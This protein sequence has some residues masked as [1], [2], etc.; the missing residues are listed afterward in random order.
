MVLL[1]LDDWRRMQIDLY[2]PPFTQRNFKCIKDLNI[3][4][5][6]MNLIEVKVGSS[7]ELIGTEDFLNK[8]PLAQSP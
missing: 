6:A 3:K 1:K 7:L 8:T 5:D 2:L 4:P